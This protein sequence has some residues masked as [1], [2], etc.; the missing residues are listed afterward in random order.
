MLP[1]RFVAEA[2]GGTVGWNDAERKVTI[3]KDN[4]VIEL[5]IDQQYAMINGLPV[6]LYTVPF[7]EN[8]R[9]YLPVRFVA[10]NLGATVLWNEDNMEV[11]IIPNK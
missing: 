10:E 8:S 4:T 11:T 9:T 7:I 5:F 6:Q 2:L 1:I 3:L